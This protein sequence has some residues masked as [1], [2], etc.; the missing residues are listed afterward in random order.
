M[1]RVIGLGVVLALA[2][3]GCGDDEDGPLKAGPGVVTE[4]WAGH[5]EA[6][7]TA[8]HRVIDGAAGVRFTTFLCQTLSDIRRLV[9]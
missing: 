4:A 3:V 2:T 6:R 9:L 5:C 7:F 1:G 8:D